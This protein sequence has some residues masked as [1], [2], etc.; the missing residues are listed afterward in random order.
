MQCGYAAYF[1]FNKLANNS[2]NHISII[3]MTE[4]SF[5]IPRDLTYLQ[6]LTRFPRLSALQIL[7]PTKLILHGSHLTPSLL[8]FFGVLPAG[9]QQSMS[10]SEMIV[11]TST[12]TRFKQVN[13]GEKIPVLL[14]DGS[15]IIHQTPFHVYLE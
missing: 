2:T 12:G 9:K 8:V 11:E 14:V 4:Y 6:P 5:S 13:E 7:S 15:S 3:G 10:W 1:F